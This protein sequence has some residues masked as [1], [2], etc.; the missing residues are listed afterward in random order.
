MFR[1]QGTSSRYIN[2]EADVTYL[3]NSLISSE[4]VFIGIRV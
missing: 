3:H 2:I 4:K 1:K